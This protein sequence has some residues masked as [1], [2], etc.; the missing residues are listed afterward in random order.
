MVQARLKPF[1]F[2]SEHTAC[3]CG[4]SL[5]FVSV[6]RR[7]VSCG[8]YDIVSGAVSPPDQLSYPSSTIVTCN[9]GFGFM[10]FGRKLVVHFCVVHTDIFCAPP[11]WCV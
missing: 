6:L 2:F 5:S 3:F 1:R 8:I 11:L 7:P 4:P 10:W 9:T